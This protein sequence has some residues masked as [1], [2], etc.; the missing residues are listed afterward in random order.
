[1]S[2]NSG[3]EMKKVFIFYLLFLFLN[4]LNIYSIEINCR[5]NCYDEIPYTTRN[6]IIELSPYCPFC[7]VNVVFLTRIGICEGRPIRDIYIESISGLS[8]S[9]FDCGIFN[10]MSDLIREVVKKVVNLYVWEDLP[11]GTMDSVDIKY[12]P[13]LLGIS[14]KRMRKFCLNGQC[15]IHRYFFIAGGQPPFYNRI[16]GWKQIVSYD[17]EC[18][19]IERHQCENICSVHVEPP[20]PIPQIKM[21]MD[22][23]EAFHRDA[24]S[25][26]FNLSEEEINIISNPSNPLRE[27][28]IFNLFGK[29]LEL[30]NVE[31]KSSHY[32]N[33][34]SYCTGF[35]LIQ[36]LS[37]DGKITRKKISL[38]NRFNF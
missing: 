21:E 3:V 18:P 15:C 12:P 11:D 2:Q 17:G 9:C 23:A 26:D 35:Y 28:K 16:I 19:T 6:M 29:L 33:L 30:H 1:M 20:Y 5:N 13:C 32:I 24:G 37:S 22:D 8:G 14:G 4:N 7:T 27:V 10:N 36:V 38:I 31:G 34:K 25:I